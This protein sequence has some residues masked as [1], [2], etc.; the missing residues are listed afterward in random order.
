MKFDN[1]EAF[2]EYLRGL[3]DGFYLQDNDGDVCDNTLIMKIAGSGYYETFNVEWQSS[4]L[5]KETISEYTFELIEGNI[6]E[7]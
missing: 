7:L 2:I 3:P 6:Y 4:R 1:F 5:F